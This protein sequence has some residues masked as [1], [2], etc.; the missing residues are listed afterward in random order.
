MTLL[1]HADRD[2]IV[3]AVPGEPTMCE[4]MSQAARLPWHGV[5]M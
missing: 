5:S 3:I 4:S 2:P 1:I